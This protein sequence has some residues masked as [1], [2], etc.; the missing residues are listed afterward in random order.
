MKTERTLQDLQARKAAL[1][2][3]LRQTE[4]LIRQDL[5]ELKADLNPMR[6]LGSFVQ[7]LVGTHP[8]A[9]PAMLDQQIDAGLTRWLDRVLPGPNLQGVRV[10]VPILVKGI[11][12]AAAPFA[13]KNLENALA[14]LIEKVKRPENPPAGQG[15]AGE[16]EA[17]PQA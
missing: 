4:A 17:V 12:H 16:P 10:L 3:K 8:T 11:L 7:N 13:F 5:N 15:G 6:Q 1:E 9:L 14:W 2:A